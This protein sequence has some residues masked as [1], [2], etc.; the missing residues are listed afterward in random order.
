[1]IALTLLKAILKFCT[2]NKLFKYFRWRYND[3]QLK[4]LNNVVKIR[5]KIRTL[6]LS[7]GGVMR[8]SVHKEIRQ[9]GSLRPRLYGLPKVHKKEVPL[10]T[11]LYMAGSS[12]HAL[13]KYLAAVIDPVLQLYSS[14]SIKDSFTFTKEMQDLQMHSK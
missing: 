7:N 2:T 12:Q 8:E 5:G 14:N 10:Q 6:Q 1:M 13:E 9:T 4:D 3:D 11:I